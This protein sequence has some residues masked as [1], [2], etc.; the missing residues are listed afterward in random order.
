MTKRTWSTTWRIC[1]IVALWIFVW[2]NFGL[3]HHDYQRAINHS[4]H[5]RCL[6][7]QHTWDAV[8]LGWHEDARPSFPPP[9][10]AS[11]PVFVEQYRV[12]NERK[13]EKLA[14]ELH[15]LGSRPTC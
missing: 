2:V 11:T 7:G 6:Q 8:T 15:R 4:D 12:G 10:L 5:N 9:S 14:R 1:L 13:L 3:Q